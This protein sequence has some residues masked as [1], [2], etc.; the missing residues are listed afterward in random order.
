MTKRMLPHFLWK[1]LR[2]HPKQRLEESPNAQA[3][4]SSLGPSRS[5]FVDPENKTPAG[6]N[7]RNEI[8]AGTTGAALPTVVR[9]TRDVSTW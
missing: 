3:R 5:D 1:P 8:L 7:K 9:L 2:R 6:D 4:Q